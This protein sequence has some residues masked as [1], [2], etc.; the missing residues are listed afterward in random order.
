MESAYPGCREA[1]RTAFLLKKC[2]EESID[3]ILASLANSTIKQYNTALKK[4]WSFCCQLKINPFYSEISDVAKFLALEFKGGAAEG[5]LN[6]YR[7]A[8]SLIQESAIGEDA[9]LKRLFKGF[10]NLKPSQPKYDVTW[11][12]QIVLNHISSLPDNDDLSLLQL[13]CKLLSLLAI[14]TAHRMQTFSL[15]EVNNIEIK[16]SENLILIKIPRRIKTSGK[17]RLQPLLRLPYF[18][19]NTKICTAATLKSY[20]DR[21]KVIR[22]KEKFLFLSCKKPH[23]RV[24]TDT[25]SRWVSQT[26]AGAGLNTD[27]FTAHSTRHASTSAAKRN[28][29]NLDT[30]RKR[31]SWTENSSTFAKFYDRPLGEPQDVFAKAIVNAV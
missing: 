1:I 15:I 10:H 7:S 11:D 28:G 24:T 3:I 16:D 9:T 2:P 12:P 26:L 29:I 23:K 8:I 13:S 21:T 20:L 31:S 25:L 17:N 18:K 22:G 5:T 4:W 6:S 27:I 30:I 14:I 19:E